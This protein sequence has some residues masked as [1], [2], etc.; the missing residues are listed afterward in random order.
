[1]PLAGKMPISG[2]CKSGAASRKRDTFLHPHGFTGVLKQLL[3]QGTPIRNRIAVDDRLPLRL[4]ARSRRF[5]KAF[6]AIFDEL[7]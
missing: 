3:V 5:G 6:F 4:A 7:V 1:M 2:R